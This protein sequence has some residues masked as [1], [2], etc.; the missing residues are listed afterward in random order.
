MRTITSIAAA[1]TLSFAAARAA[2]GAS[3]YLKDGTAIIGTVVAATARDVTVH[4]ADGTTKTVSADQIAR[5]DY[6]E[7]EPVSAAAAPAV[8]A[9]LAY[10]EP[11]PTQE[12][13]LDLGVIVPMDHL[14][15]SSLDGGSVSNGGPGPQVGLTFTPLRE[16]NPASSSISARAPRKRAS[17]R[18][19]ESKRSSWSLKTAD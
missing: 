6:S 3:V 2:Q 5:I 15:F 14:D 8:P 4:R 17:R 16:S 19:P 10:R 1:I 13:S 18:T 12:I 11:V 7:P 9:K